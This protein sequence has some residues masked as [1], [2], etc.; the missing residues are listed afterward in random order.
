MTGADPAAFADIVGARA[1]VR[2][3]RRYRGTAPLSS[4]GTGSLKKGNL[5]RAQSRNHRRRHRLPMHDT[6]TLWE[7]S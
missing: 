6:N 5:E 7:H 3:A 1:S 4:T 2:G